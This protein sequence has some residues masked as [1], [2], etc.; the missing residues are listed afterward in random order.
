MHISELKEAKK[1]LY[2]EGEYA[3]FRAEDELGMYRGVINRKGEIVW[4]DKWRHI[5][6]RIHGYPS[7]LKTVNDTREFVYYDIEKHVFVDPPVIEESHR[8]KAQQMV[9]KAPDIPFFANTPGLFNYKSL[10]YLSDDYIAFSS[11][12]MYWGVRD[13]QGHIIFPEKFY[14]VFEGGEPNH[15]KVTIEE[16]GKRKRILKDGV[17]DDRG[18]WIIPPTYDSL[19][20]RRA[21]Y[22]A[23]IKEPRKKPK[24]GLLDKH[25]NVLVPFEYEFL[26][27][28]YT[29]DLISAKKR[30][31]FLFINS[32]N[33]KIDLF[34][35]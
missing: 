26:D 31:K 2:F 6:M 33:E 22:V 15:F 30:G 17:I 27:P 7:I 35:R 21:Y 11:E 12:K 4:N 23:Y 20:W 32:R 13:I 1:I 8:S 9:D 16:K 24:C 18:E 5:V 3:I 19:H 25:G 10:R 14:D 29:E 34:N 28:S